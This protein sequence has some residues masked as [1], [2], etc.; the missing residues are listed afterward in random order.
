MK[1]KLSGPDAYKCPF[2]FK[3]GDK[4][5]FKSGG[6]PTGI[7]E[8]GECECDFPT[9][10]P[11]SIVYQIRRSDGIPWTAKQQDIELLPED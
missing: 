4:V 3:I 2:E 9:P 5:R 8:E 7:V 1:A 11:F 10:G 6:S